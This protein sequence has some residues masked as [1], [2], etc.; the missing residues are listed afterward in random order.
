MSDFSDLL[1]VLDE[2]D[3]KELPRDQLADLWILLGA[4]TGSYAVGTVLVALAD[5]DVA[6]RAMSHLVS[7]V[8]DRL[9]S[10]SRRFLRNLVAH[11]S[12]GD[13]QEWVDEATR[14]L[15]S[16][17][18]TGDPEAVVAE[19]RSALTRAS[20]GRW[21]VS[22]RGTGKTNL[23]VQFLAD[24]LS[25]D[26][27]LTAAA[28]LASFHPDLERE[29][30]GHI[31]SLLATIAIRHRLV[32]DLAG[33]PRQ[34]VGPEA[35][36]DSF[37][38]QARIAGEAMASIWE[39]PVLEPAAAAVALGAK[40][41]NREKVRT[42]RERSWLLGL[43]KGRGYVYPQFQFDLTSRDVYPEVRSANEILEA[44]VDPWGV[45]SWWIGMNDRL[46]GRPVELVGT[47][48]APEI[49][50]AAETVLEPVG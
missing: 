11:S 5:V 2:N 10:A 3:D 8:D 16:P 32:D 18:D 25:P 21:Q 30:S 46:D 49:K 36:A 1:G 31:R 50:L 24:R 35:V 19:L 28:E 7:P 14:T 40:A 42:Y 41:T 45:A 26:E 4:R 44:G 13:V 34:L 27:R 38:R 33:D 20:E 23:F 15:I 37:L 22:Q 9:S 29:E 43:P 6:V 39:Y 47:S 48:R 17:G 12:P